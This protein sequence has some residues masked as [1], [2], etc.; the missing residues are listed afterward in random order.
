MPEMDPK[1]SNILTYSYHILNAAANQTAVEMAAA[2]EATSGDVPQQ[3]VPWAGSIV[4]I[5]IQIEAARTAG[6]LTIQPSIDGVAAGTTLAID[7]DPTQYNYVA[8]RRG[9]YPFTAGQR[10]GCLWTTSSDWAAGTT[11]SV[12]VVLFVHIEEA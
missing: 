7:D 1:K 9:R 11:P 6:S 4:G 8:W 3:P 12:H 5:S 2:G 10:L